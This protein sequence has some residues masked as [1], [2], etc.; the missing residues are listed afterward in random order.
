MYTDANST[1]GQEAYPRPYMDTVTGSN[2]QPPPMAPCVSQGGQSTS[3]SASCNTQIPLTGGDANQ[4]SRYIPPQDI[5]TELISNKRLLTFKLFYCLY[6]AGF[7]SIFPLITV[8]F[9]QLG[10]NAF[11]AGILVGIRPLVEMF[12]A[13]FW[14]S[15]PEKHHK[16]MLLGSLGSFILFTIST[17]F[18]RP[19]ATACVIFN[20]THYVLYTPYSDRTD[21]FYEE[22]VIEKDQSSATKEPELLGSEPSSVRSKRA[23]PGLVKEKVAKKQSPLSR[24]LESI[25]PVYRYKP[26]P[27]HIIGKSPTSIDYTLNYNKD[28]HA[29]Y[30][31][32][33]FSTVV[34]KWDDVKE[35]FFLLL[36][37]ILLGEFFSCPA[38]TLA[39]TATLNYLGER[40][41]LYGRQRMFGSVGW[42]I[43]MFFVG[44]ALD[45]STD[46]PGHPCGAH[47][48]E[49]NYNVCFTYFAFLMLAA[50]AVAYKF[51]FDYENVSYECDPMDAG[52]SLETVNDPGP[53]S[54][55]NTAPPINPPPHILEQNRKKFEFIDRMK[56]AVFA[57]RTR[58][59][60][61]WLTVLRHMSNVKYG[62]FLLV[63]FFMGFGIGLVFTFLFWHLQDLGGKKW[64][65]LVISYYSFSN[66][67]YIWSY[68]YS[69]ICNFYPYCH[70][71]YSH[72]IRYFMLP[73]NRHSKSF[74]LSFSR[75]PRF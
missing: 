33:A 71:F 55:F 46:F 22:Q 21:V 53:K 27:G 10:M 58:K 28:K 39:D 40:T 26:P 7:S 50:T 30:V 36:L 11:Q 45:R 4:N 23:P 16:I 49:R 41:D 72:C 67:S 5:L 2:H 43:T 68:W 54:L 19:P 63:I 70:S 75:E 73:L 59:M 61:D 42:A 20:A 6:F 14:S 57:Q 24:F 31:S 12:S 47:E 64:F 48:R 62:S 13:P 25:D 17:A 9:K 15:F 74:W 34:Y 52:G 56:S 60:P 8:Y 65:S 66:F 37:L 32:P 3:A 35:V 69:Y 38:V 51:D 18:I 44:I 29:S 1:S